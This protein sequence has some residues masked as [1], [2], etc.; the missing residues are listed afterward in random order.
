MV[1]RQLVGLA[2]TRDAEDDEG[3][4][5]VRSVETVPLC[6]SEKDQDKVYKVN[7]NWKRFQNDKV[8][9]SRTPPW[10]KKN[11]KQKTTN[12]LKNQL[13]QVSENHRKFGKTPSTFIEEQQ[14]TLASKH[15]ELRCISLALLHPSLSNSEGALEA[16]NLTAMIAEGLLGRRE[17]ATPP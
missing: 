14:W 16:H 15:G 13:S 5:E 7:A 1:D 6:R 8:R 2:S 10:K 11:K 3:N 9:S 4:S 12:T 17:Q